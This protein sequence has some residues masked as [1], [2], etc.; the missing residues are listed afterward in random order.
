MRQGTMYTLYTNEIIIGSML[1]QMDPPTDGWMAAEVNKIFDGRNDS[2]L[3]TS[4][5][6]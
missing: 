1:H 6:C 2:I 4:Y 3:T 5:S